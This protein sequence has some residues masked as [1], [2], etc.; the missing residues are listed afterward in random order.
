LYSS[1]NIIRVMESRRMRQM[2]YVMRNAYKVLVTSKEDTT[3]E[4]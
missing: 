1:I 3:S 2:G 4:T